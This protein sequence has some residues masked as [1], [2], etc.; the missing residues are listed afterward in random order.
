MA[1]V[2]VPEGEFPMGGNDRLGHAKPEHTVYLDAFWIDKTEVTN[3]MF[4][5][6]T[7]Q[8]GYIGELEK[9]NKIYLYAGD[10][11]WP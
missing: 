1:M 11:N 3:S 7:S 2:Y 6:F 4:A 8:S 9:Q 5:R 10:L